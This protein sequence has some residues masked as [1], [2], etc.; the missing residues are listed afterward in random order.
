MLYVYVTFRCYIY[1]SNVYV[2]VLHV[3]VV[4]VCCSVTCRCY[5]YI[6]CICSPKSPNLEVY[7]SIFLLKVLNDLDLGGIK[8]D[9]LGLD[10]KCLCKHRPKHVQSTPELD[11]GTSIH[12]SSFEC[13]FWRGA[14]VFA[15][16]LVTQWVL[17]TGISALH[18]SKTQGLKF[19][20]W[21]CLH[22]TI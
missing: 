21:L 14:P 12:P 2:T 13:T 18:W 3:D 16:L 6:P 22:L 9:F 10:E 20:R 19:Q 5:M 1:M 7:F 17:Q 15:F 4:Y 11:A 8:L